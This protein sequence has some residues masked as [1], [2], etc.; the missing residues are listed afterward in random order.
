[1]F[2]PTINVFFVLTKTFT[3]IGYLCA[4]VAAYF[5]HLHQLYD[6]DNISDYFMF[7]MKKVVIINCYKCEIHFSTKEI[8]EEDEKRVAWCG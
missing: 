1:M 4:Q 7:Q 8:I 5:R 3:N 2:V 6:R